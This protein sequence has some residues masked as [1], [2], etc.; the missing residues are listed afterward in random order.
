[1]R[2]SASTSRMA[3]AR[4]RSIRAKT[5]VTSSMMAGDV[6]RTKRRRDSKRRALIPDGLMRAR[7]KTFVS[8]TTLG[9]V[10]LPRADGFHRPGDPAVDLLLEDLSEFLSNRR[11]DIVEFLEPLVGFIGC[12]D[13]NLQLF[14]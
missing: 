14:A 8:K 6:M 10:T 4:S 13:S 12:F 9:L 5:S 2:S 11:K 7:T 1:M 3:F